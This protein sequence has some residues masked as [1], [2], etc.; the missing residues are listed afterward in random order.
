MGFSLSGRPVLLA[1]GIHIPECYEAPPCCASM[2]G[3]LPTLLHAD[4]ISSAS[5][6]QIISSFTDVYIEGSLQ[7]NQGGL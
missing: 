1:D 6:P 3:C 7:V 4:G 5:D 2:S